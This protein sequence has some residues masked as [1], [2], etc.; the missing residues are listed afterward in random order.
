MKERGS[1]VGELRGPRSIL[2]F[3]S[4]SLNTNFFVAPDFE[5]RQ[6]TGAAVRS[7]A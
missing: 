1:L 4:G 2:D 7:V 3:D 5:A 6:R